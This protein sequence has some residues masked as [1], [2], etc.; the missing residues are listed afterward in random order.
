MDR[1]KPP[2]TPLNIIK[3]GFYINNH[4]SAALLSRRFYPYL[5]YPMGI[6]MDIQ[7]TFKLKNKM[8]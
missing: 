4:L 8:F 5:K 3:N 7:W 6:Q 1:Q 2:K